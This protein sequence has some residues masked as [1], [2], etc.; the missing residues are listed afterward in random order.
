M[1]AIYSFGMADNISRTLP[2]AVPLINQLAP[3]QSK[4]RGHQPHKSGVP[5]GGDR[6]FL[7]GMG[8]T[9]RGGI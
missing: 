6:V 5:S 1:E 3:P 7:G 4:Y 2:A 8:A 9:D